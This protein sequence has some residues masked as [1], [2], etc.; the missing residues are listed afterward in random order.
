M[1]DLERLTLDATVPVL[2]ARIDALEEALGL[3]LQAPPEY[4][5]TKQES[6]L[7]GMLHKGGVLTKEKAY[8]ALYGH[9]SDPPYDCVLK[10]MIWK[11]RRKLEPFG[12]VIVTHWG[13]GWELVR[14][15]KE[16][17]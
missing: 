16:A 14:T 13:I 17:A 8:T 3:N 2:Q 9:K 7:W 12:I 4:V 6:A 1:T 15:E 10:A 11:L 5:L